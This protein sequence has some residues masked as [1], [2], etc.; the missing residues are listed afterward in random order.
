MKVSDFQQMQP[1]NT[2][3]SFRVTA[4][5]SESSPLLLLTYPKHK[6]LQPPQT[7]PAL[8]WMSCQWNP[9]VHSFLNY[10]FE[11]HLYFSYNPRSLLLCEI[12]FSLFILLMSNWIVSTLAHYE[13]NSHVHLCPSLL[14]DIGIQISCVYTLENCWIIQVDVYIYFI[15]IC[16]G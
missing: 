13:Q 12:Y 3:T 16:Q 10:T 15:R 8:P 7:I 5:S 1:S 2:C 4:I 6:I 14:V 9:S 11:F